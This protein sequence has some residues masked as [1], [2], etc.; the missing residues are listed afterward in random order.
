MYHT[1]FRDLV[2]FNPIRDG[3]E[4]LKIISG[5]A[6]HTMASWHSTEIFFTGNTTNR[7][8]PVSWYVPV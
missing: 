1:D 2:L 5:Y 6:T 8:Y 3:A 4:Q 7:Y